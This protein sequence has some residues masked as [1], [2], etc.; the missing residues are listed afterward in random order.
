MPWL[1]RNPLMRTL[2]AFTAAMVVCAGPAFAQA[3]QPA[4]NCDLDPETT[5]SLAADPRSVYLPGQHPVQ[6]DRDP[7]E[8][9][10]QD[11]A[12]ENSEQRQRDLFDCGVD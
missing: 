2:L 9:S 3:D 11:Q 4:R 10:W 8:A 12:Q 6:A 5:G 1:I 7:P